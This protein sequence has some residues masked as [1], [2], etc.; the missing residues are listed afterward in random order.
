MESRGV[1][2]NK[3][4]RDVPVTLYLD[5]NLVDS[6]E[7]IAKKKGL[8]PGA[9][10][11]RVVRDFVREEGQGVHSVSSDDLDPLS[12]SERTSG[13]PPFSE[14]TFIYTDGGCRGNPGPGGWAAVLYEGS[15]PSRISG[16]ERETTNNRMEIK[17]AIE[18]LKTLN[19]P[20]KVKVHSDSAYLINA[21]TKGWLSGWEKNGWRKS[22]KKP[23][24]NKDLWRELLEASRPHEVE[25]VKV[26][27]HAGNPG[28]ELCHR[29]VQ[30]AINDMN[31]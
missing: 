25:W 12:G 4:R 5:R 27:G 1:F 24:Q 26:E 20:S 22:N 28:N 23:I 31:I 6:V 30:A 9:L 10:L 17:A 2:R 16:G 18:G 8:A 7:D 15:T 19:K 3:N 13:V 29:L 21:L 14:T 11:N